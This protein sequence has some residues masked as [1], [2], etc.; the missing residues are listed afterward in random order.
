MLLHF[1]R[2]YGG[3]QGRPKVLEIGPGVGAT[4]KFFS[5]VSEVHGL[6]PSRAALKYAKKRVLENLVCGFG[7]QLP[8]HDGAF[9]MV[10]SADVVEHIDNPEPLLLEAFRVLRPGGLL[11]VIVPAYQWLWSTRDVR[12]HHCR[13]YRL[14][15]LRRLFRGSGFVILKATY[16]NAFY[17]PAFAAAVLVSRAVQRGRADLAFDFLE[18]PRALN[19]LLTWILDM[20]T[21]CLRRVNFPAGSSVFCAG[22]RPT[23]AA[24]DSQN[25]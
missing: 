24:A 8:Y 9:D 21:R 3:L 11:M 25:R 12:L 7:Q 22:Q 6:D 1:F 14:G 16:I 13:R 10:M 20:E 2:Q 18:V 19:A 4:L 5:E 17:L 23:T 15:E